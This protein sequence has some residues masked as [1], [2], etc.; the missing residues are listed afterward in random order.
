MKKLLV[1]ALVL[2]MA[3]MAS[4]AL[5]LSIGVSGAVANGDGSYTVAPSDHLT[6]SLT[7]PGG[8]LTDDDSG[9]FIMTCNTAL[10]TISGGVIEN[11]ATW[12]VNGLADDA[13]GAGA[14]V[15]DGENGVWGGVGLFNYTIPADSLLFSGID[16]HC[17]AVGD[18]TIGVYTHDWSEITGTLDTV[19]IHQI[20]EPFTMALLGLGGLFLRRRSK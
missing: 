4:A 3:T 1:L 17:E 14:P 19:V 8:I 15:M 7:T 10:G 16:F 5:T 20:P 6:L 9:D 18:V 12:W 2:S 13:A 11:A